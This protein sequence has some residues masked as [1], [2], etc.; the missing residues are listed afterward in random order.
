[1]GHSGSLGDESQ[2]TELL[3][4]SNAG[5][6][7]V[8]VDLVSL[9]Q[10]LAGAMPTPRDSTLLSVIRREYQAIASARRRGLLWHEIADVLT[11]GGIPVSPGLLRK[12]YS[13]I[14]REGTTQK[15]RKS[16]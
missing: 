14:G 2:M 7:R 1:M 5:F 15:G 9:R 16:K 12:Y 11:D 13:R 10:A 3:L 8:Q 6:D 4:R